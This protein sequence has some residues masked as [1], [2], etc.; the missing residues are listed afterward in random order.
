MTLADRIS[1]ARK[2]H[3]ALTQKELGAELGVDALTISRW[4]RGIVEP[5]P[6]HLRRLAE[7]TGLPVSW[8][9][10]EDPD[11]VAATEAAA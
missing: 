7:L 11:P 6:R 10:G 8:F 4:E 5:R 2:Q 1:E 3:L 9:F